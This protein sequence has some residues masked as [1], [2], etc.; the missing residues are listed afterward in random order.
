MAFGQDFLRAFFGNDYLKDY[1]HASKT[2]RTNGYENA[3]KL[4]FL[5]HV[6]LTV[7]TQIPALRNIYTNNESAVLGLLCKTID[8]PRYQIDVEVLNQYNRKRLDRKKSII[9]Q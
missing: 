9:N 4:K 8:L 6:Y 1:T 3:P 7:N 2:F 5:F